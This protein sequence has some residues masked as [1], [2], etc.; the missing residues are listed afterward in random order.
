MPAVDA[1]V[2]VSTFATADDAA[3]VARAVVEERLAA[4][5]NLLPGVRS[6]Y[7]WQGAIEDASEVLAVFKTTAATFDALR[8]R[9]VQLHG[10]DVPE[11]IAWPIAQGHPAYLAWIAGEL[12]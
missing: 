12:G 8:A 2:V 1:L 6:I 3:R 9:I 11:V 7:R 10:Y 5:V 4:C